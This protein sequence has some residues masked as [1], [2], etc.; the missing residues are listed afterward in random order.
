MEKET[1][2]TPN[3]ETIEA[4]KEYDEMKTHPENYKRYASF[5]EAMNDCLKK[6]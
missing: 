6:D 1:S 3:T 5:Q 2:K 4:I